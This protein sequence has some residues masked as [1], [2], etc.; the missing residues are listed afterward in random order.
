MSGFLDLKALVE[1]IE[2]QE[3]GFGKRGNEFTF[4]RCVHVGHR[5]V[6]ESAHTCAHTHACKGHTH[7][8]FYK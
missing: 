2:V 1:K 6:F 5:V 8:N 7:S 3:A 4:Y